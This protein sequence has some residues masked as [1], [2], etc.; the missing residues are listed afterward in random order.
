MRKMCVLL[1]AAAWLAGCSE[2]S[3]PSPDASQASGLR[4][5]GDIAFQPCTLANGF[6]TATVEAQC[7]KLEV[8]E[9]PDAPQGRKIA[10]N[11]AWLPATEEGAAADDPVFFLAG[12]PGQAAVQVWPQIDAAFAEV[13]KNRHIILVDQRGTGESNPLACRDSEGENAF[14]DDQDTSTD[15]AIAF[16]RQC[17]ADLDADP[18]FY[19]TTDAVRDLDSVRRALGV[20]RINLVGGSYGTRV[21]QQYAM[22]YP[23]Q[24][25]SIV[26]DGVVPNTLV[27]GSEHSRNLDQS[28]LLQFEKCQQLPACKRV[29]GSDLREQLRG[30]MSRLAAN[31]VTTTYR[32]PFNGQQKQGQVSAG[33]VA[34]LT[35]M[36]AY[37]PQAAALLPLVLNEA[38][39][40]HYGPLMSLATLV[41]GQMSDQFMH[42]MQLSVICAED[43]DRLPTDNP[44]DADTVLGNEMN[45][46]L[47]AQCS[48]WPTGKRPAD[49]NKP[50][51]TDV[52]ALLL[53]GE[54][55]PV[56]PPRYGDEVVKQ[57]PNGRHLVLKGQGHGS[58]AVG[59]V[60][61]LLG[62]FIENTD[63]KALDA[64]CLE[65]LGYVP[66]FTSFNGWE[67]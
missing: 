52:P 42:G 40:G 36:F 12:G 26:I 43:G 61:K 50:L 8:A 47:K 18:R 20:A 34:L 16:A 28:L 2:P 22:H 32:D 19:T 27:L 11:I 25:R 54:F 35:R 31:P 64:S 55:D 5:Y 59:C 48:V 24:T 60:P 37:V 30:L 51:A 33:S 1:M 23:Q 41:D 57:L 4:T 14:S 13:R 15:A 49:F 9:N 67:P 21:A 38:D 7:A 10:L 66:P 65:A 44:A 56:T 58:F 39:R 63:A 17:A 3:A 45:R 6:S 29:F 46:Y 53:S 62:Q